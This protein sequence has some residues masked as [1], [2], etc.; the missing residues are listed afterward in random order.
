MSPA[1]KMGIEIKKF[2][3]DI[4]KILENSSTHYMIIIR[5]MAQ[6]GSSYGIN[7]ANIV[8]QKEVWDEIN[9]EYQAS[10]LIDVS[11]FN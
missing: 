9:T 5:R 6:L 4:N 3:K 7:I 8:R 2:R 11:R 1:A 10:D